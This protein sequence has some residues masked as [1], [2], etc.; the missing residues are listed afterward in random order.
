[1]L[2]PADLR[3]RVSPVVADCWPHPPFHD[4]RFRPRKRAFATR[5]GL[6]PGGRL[7]AGRSPLSESCY[8][9]TI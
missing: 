1:M 4:D 5:S 6:A 7:G 8:H 3:A 2:Y 9:A